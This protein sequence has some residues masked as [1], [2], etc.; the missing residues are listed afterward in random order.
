[1]KNY[2]DKPVDIDKILWEA[3]MLRKE[4]QT[5]APLWIFI[6]LLASLFFAMVYF[7]H[8]ANSSVP[9]NND[10][11][12]V[13]MPTSCKK[14]VASVIKEFKEDKDY[15]IVQM[16]THSQPWLVA[17]VDYSHMVRTLLYVFRYDADVVCMAMAGDPEYK[18]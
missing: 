8:P 15:T 18:A 2:N 9:T 5:G 12:I 6:G 3:R 4:A 13:Q 7:G 14:G 11:F 1:M 17:R 10:A 16:P